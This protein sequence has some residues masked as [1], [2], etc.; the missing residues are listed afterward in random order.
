MLV[1]FFFVREGCFSLLVH[2]EESPHQKSVSELHICLYTL[3]RALL[4]SYV[5]DHAASP[6]YYR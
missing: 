1:M 4:G 3:P 6:T 2:S 5:C